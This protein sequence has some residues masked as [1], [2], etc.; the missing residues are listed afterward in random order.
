MSNIRKAARLH[1][2]EGDGEKMRE[3]E[4]KMRLDISSRLWAEE[5]L[6]KKIGRIR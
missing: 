1:A 5:P 2:N 4:K 6:C 3:M